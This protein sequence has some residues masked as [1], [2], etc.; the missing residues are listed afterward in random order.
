MFKTVA[1]SCHKRQ[2]ITPVA[3]F[4]NA[5]GGPQLLAFS[6]TERFCVQ[7]TADTRR[8]GSM[9]NYEFKD[10]MSRKELRVR[11]ATWLC[12]YHHK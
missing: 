1:F 7:I 6:R 9:K 4:D 5:N 8:G 2:E 3:L 12:N 11:K 10:E